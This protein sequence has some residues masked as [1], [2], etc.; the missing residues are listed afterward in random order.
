VLTPSHKRSCHQ[1][2]IGLRTVAQ[3]F[4]FFSVSV[5][6]C[7]P[8]LLMGS[9]LLMPCGLFFLFIFSALCN[10]IEPLSGATPATITSTNVTTS[11]TMS[12]NCHHPTQLPPPLRWIS[13][14]ANHISSSITNTATNVM[15]SIT[16]SKCFHYQCQLCKLTMLCHYLHL[17]SA[18]PSHD[19]D[20]CLTLTYHRHHHHHHHTSSSMTTQQ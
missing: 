5:S 16:T 14:N 1:F 19:H 20:Q 6:W 8:P 3:H 13:I 7:A 2:P 10:P 18:I 12:P 15:T 11:T 4:F 17:H 9:T